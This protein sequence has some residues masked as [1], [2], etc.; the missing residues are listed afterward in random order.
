MY[1]FSLFAKERLKDFV[2]SCS[3]F[4]SP[5]CSVIEVPPSGKPPARTAYIIISAAS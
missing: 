3:W 5:A 2:L 1:F 4:Q